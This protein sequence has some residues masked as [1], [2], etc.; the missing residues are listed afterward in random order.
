MLDI[1]SL[2]V[3]LWV[4]EICDIHKHILH[5]GGKKW[6]E[7]GLRMKPARPMRPYVTDKINIHAINIL[8]ELV[9]SV[10][11]IRIS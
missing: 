9:G 4:A 2:S 3:E 6:E 11:L 7:D 8:L 10:M 1:G 5:E